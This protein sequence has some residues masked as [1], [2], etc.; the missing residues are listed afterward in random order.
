[1][2]RDSRKGDVRIWCSAPINRARPGC[3]RSEELR[4]AD[5]ERFVQAAPNG[6]LP[7]V[8]GAESALHDVGHPCGCQN[9][10]HVH[11]AASL[12]GSQPTSAEQPRACSFRT[13]TGTELSSDLCQHPCIFGSH[14]VARRKLQCRRLCACSSS[15]SLPAPKL[16]RSATRVS[17]STSL[18]LILA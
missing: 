3:G 2:P 15:R 18:Y 13:A 16:W 11:D 10:R 14:S 1:M 12:P 5:T 7:E 6:Q 4:K 8:P 17:F 9:G